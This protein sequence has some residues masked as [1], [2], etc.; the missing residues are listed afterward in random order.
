MHVLLRC[1][2]HC[3]RRGAP[4]CSRPCD[5]LLRGVVWLAWT[6]AIVRH[7]QRRRAT[8]FFGLP[9]SIQRHVLLS[10]LAVRRLAVL[11]AS[12]SDYFMSDTFLAFF[13]PSIIV[14]T[15]FPLS[16][17]GQFIHHGHVTNTS[18]IKI[19]SNALLMFCFFNGHSLRSPSCPPR[20]WRK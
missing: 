10:D 9:L 17:L 6:A 7:S 8:K 16:F 4:P 13:L 5:S 3:R 19:K 14:P 18:S 2:G 1:L 20:R 12:I 15:F 11:I